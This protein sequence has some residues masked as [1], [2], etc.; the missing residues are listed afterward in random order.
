MLSQAFLAML[1]RQNQRWVPILD[2]EIHVRQGYAAYDSGIAKDVFIKDIT[3]RPYVGQV[4][5][6]TLSMPSCQQH[7][8]IAAVFCP[9]TKGR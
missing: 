9:V 1:K 4:R 8:C 5:F 2:P 7:A 3:G 6:C